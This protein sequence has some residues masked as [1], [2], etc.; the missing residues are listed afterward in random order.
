MAVDVPEQAEETRT[1]DDLTHLER[2]RALTTL[3]EVLRQAEERHAA[4]EIIG[5]RGD[6]ANAHRAL[7][8]FAALV[9]S[10]AIK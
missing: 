3:R 4:G 5:E 10:V 9:A 1:F 7:S 8:A 6:F 2:H